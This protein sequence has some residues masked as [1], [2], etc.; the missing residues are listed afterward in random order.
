[1]TLIKGQSLLIQRTDPLAL[2]GFLVC[3]PPWVCLPSRSQS[4]ETFI[5]KLLKSFANK[6]RGCCGLRTCN[7]LL[8]EEERERTTRKVTGC[9]KQYGAN[10]SAIKTKNT[11]RLCKDKV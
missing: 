6:P 7:S 5:E 2:T 10:P 3:S 8:F 1:M 9:G 4:L 11:L